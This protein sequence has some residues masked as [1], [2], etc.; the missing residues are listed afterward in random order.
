MNLELSGKTALVTGA[1]TGLGRTIAATLATEGARVA[2]NY[3]TKP[4]EAEA[5]VEAIRLRD[6]IGMPVAGDITRDEDVSAMF[7]AVEAEFG[8]INV[9]VNNA[10]CCPVGPAAE[11]ASEVFMQAVDVNLVGTFRCCR[12]FVA[13]LEAAG[14][15]GRIVNISSQAAFRGSRSGKSAYDSSKMGVVGLTISLARELAPK[16]FTVNCVAPG[17]MLTEMIAEAVAADPDAF[18]K[19]VPL[20]RMGKTQEIADVVAFLAS[21]RASYMTG[22]TV[23]VSGGLAMH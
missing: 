15:T 22:A 2:V 16:G 23:D 13:R 9:L 7:A 1:A 12:E 11:L 8:P 5:V 3:R 21:E 17:L 18:N 10:A 14:Q 4:E 6:G 20:G 19:R